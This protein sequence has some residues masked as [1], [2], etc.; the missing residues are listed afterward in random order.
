[1]IGITVLESALS[2][3]SYGWLWA[4]LFFVFLCL[5][6][7]SSILGYVEVITGSIFNIKPGLISYRPLITFCV[8]VVFF[9]LDIFMA[10]QG[11]IHVYHLL[12][13]YISQWPQLLITLL[14]VLPAV[15]CHG[16]R[17]IMKVIITKSSYIF[18]P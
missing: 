12:T 13:T 16:T 18:S 3:I 10:A 5:V 11:G 17:N 1:L 8:L 6:C 14:T 2:Q 4:G 7:I 9:L 15:L